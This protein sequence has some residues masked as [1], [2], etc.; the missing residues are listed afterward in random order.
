MTR[1]KIDWTDEVWNPVR[2]CSVVS[3][4]CKNCY[5]MRQAHRFSGA[6]QPYEGLTEL[7]SGKPTWTGAV[8]LVP[9]A[10]EMPLRWRKPRRVFVNSMSDLFH[11]GVPF[12]FIV[13]VFAVMQASPHHTFQV[14]TKRPERALAFFEW[15]NDQRGVTFKAYPDYVCAYEAA[16][17]LDD[18]RWSEVRDCGRPWPLPNVWLG[19]SVEDQAAA[20]KRIPLLLRCPAAVRW[21]SAEPLL[22]PV[23]LR[24]DWVRMMDGTEWEGTPAFEERATYAELLDWV[25]VG[26]ESGPGH[27][28]L[29]LAWARSI[30]AQ[31]ADAGVPFFM[32][33]TGS[34]YTDSEDPSHQEHP[35]LIERPMVSRKGGHPADLAAVG[36]NIREWPKV[37][38]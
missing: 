17:A 26:G 31:C 1:S 25:V 32:K 18:N 21:I 30:R 10:L 5:A 13:R 20:D 15:L 9:D 34:S 3:A 22:G 35:N 19:V 14:L 6:G 7:R 33:Q 12:E 16:R 38:A 23:D 29:D 11:D 27:R 36:L 4:G 8:K 37:A 28:T 24:Q 2:G